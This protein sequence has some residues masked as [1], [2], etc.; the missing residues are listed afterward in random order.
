MSSCKKFGE[1]KEFP[2]T[3]DV[4]FT[5][6]DAQEFADFIEEVRKGES[7]HLT[8]AMMQFLELLENQSDN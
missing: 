1:K 8:N 3:L 2:E 5:F 7:L 4:T 6:R